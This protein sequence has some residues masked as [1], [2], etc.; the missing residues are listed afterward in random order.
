MLEVVN[1]KIGDVAEMAV[2]FA[3]KISEEWFRADVIKQS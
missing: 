3:K 1:V 2:G